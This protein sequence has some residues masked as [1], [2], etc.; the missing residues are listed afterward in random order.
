M[1]LSGATTPT[2]SEPGIDG[3]KR[4]L[5]I[6]GTS[7]S[8]CL[9]SY[10]GHLLRESYP[11]AEMQLVYSTAPAD[12]AIF[13]FI[14]CG[15]NCYATGPHVTHDGDSLYLELGTQTTMALFL[16]LQPQQMFCQ[17]GTET[18]RKLKKK[19][20]IFLIIHV[21]QKAVENNSFKS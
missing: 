3:N 2:Q 15:D 13:G 6:T 7:S 19:Y 9:V 18:R 4:V 14:F 1:T 10:T 8:D 12:W 11:N 20:V 21:Q 17:M 5:C 16:R